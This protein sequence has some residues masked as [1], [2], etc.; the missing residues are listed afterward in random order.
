MFIICSSLVFADKETNEYAAVDKKTMEIP[1]SET[2]TTSSIATY[3]KVNFSTDMDRVRAA[4]V[5]TASTLEY[6]IDNLYAINFYELPEEKIAKSLKTHKGIC[7]NYATIYNDI[8]MKCG[9][10]SF[11]VSGCTKQGATTDLLP[12]AW[13]ATMVD[14]E[15]YLFDPT[16]G[17]GVISDG[18]FIRKLNNSY[19]KVNPALMIKT[20]MPFDPM[21]ECLNYTI[22]NPEFA[23]GLTGINNSKAYF[24]YKD[25]IAA[26]EQLNETERYAAEAR[27]IEQTGINNALVYNRLA[28][29]KQVIEMSKQMN[30]I[31]NQNEIAT[32]YNRAVA[33]FNEGINE[34]NVFIHYRNEQFMP[35]KTDPEIQGMVDSAAH[36]IGRAKIRLDQI[37]NPNADIAAMITAIEKSIREAEQNLDEQKEFIS[38]YFS[39]SKLIRKTMF[40]KKL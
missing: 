19:F 1:Q 25:T 23:K 4:Y 13:C 34:L 16:W 36:K 24:S 18:Q 21:W 32:I 6:D 8:C 7:E 40:Y 5:W 39:K 31:N 26:Y 30:K 15:W 20:H 2:T 17:S 3:I 9:I 12:H 35:H 27:R 29:L 38:R 11:V 14:N 22:T 28:N 10:K 37:S 33:E